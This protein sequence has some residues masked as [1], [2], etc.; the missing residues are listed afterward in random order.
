MHGDF[1]MLLL[2]VSIYVYRL[3]AELERRRIDNGPLGTLEQSDAMWCALW[4]PIVLP[5]RALVR[6]GRGRMPR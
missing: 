5:W 4:W 2:W 3:S 6:L 1:L